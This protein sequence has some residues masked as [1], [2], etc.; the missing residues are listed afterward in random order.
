VPKLGAKIVDGTGEPKKSGVEREYD[1]RLEKLEISIGARRCPGLGVPCGLH[2][3]TQNRVKW[4]F[5]FPAQ[6]GICLHNYR[7]LPPQPM[8]FASKN[9]GYRESL[10]LNAV[11]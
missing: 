7:H 11:A 3:H 8:A 10:D 4:V 1:T 2:D 9:Q 5:P 6:N